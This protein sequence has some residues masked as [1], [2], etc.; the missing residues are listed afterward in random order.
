MCTNSGGRNTEVLH[1]ACERQHWC[2]DIESARDKTSYLPTLPALPP[3]PLNSQWG[4]RLFMSWSREQACVGSLAREEVCLR[5]SQKCVC[6][7]V[8][9]H[10]GKRRWRREREES[11][12]VG[13]QEVRIRG[14]SD[15]Q[16]GKRR[17]VLL[18][19][20]PLTHSPPTH[21]LKEL[22]PQALL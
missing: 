20:S 19:I 14:R 22:H 15:R 13:M 11:V 1:F 9:A 21:T 6:V 10:T 12:Y 8:C 2:S 18:L 17:K 4:R 7:P 3:F 16:E 5:E